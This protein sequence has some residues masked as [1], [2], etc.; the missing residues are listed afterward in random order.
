MRHAPENT[1]TGFAACMN[2]RLGFE[3]DIRRSKDGVLVVMHDGD[4]KRTTNGKGRVGD[5]TLAEIKKLDAGRWFAADF[6][7]EPVPTLDAVFALLKKMG[8]ADTLVCLDI[9]EE[10][11]AMESDIVMLAKKH[12]VLPKV[13]CIGRAILESRARA[14]LRAADAKTPVAVLAQKSEDLRQALAEKDADWIYVRFMPTPAEVKAVHAQGKRVFL[15]GTLSIGNEPENWQRARDAGVDA[16]LTD[17]P[18]ECQL[19][20]RAGQKK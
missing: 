8:G 2:L 5:L 19:L 15:S 7:G 6:A 3:L 14:K 20:W 12:D 1:L 16:L 13:L 17:Y 9:K 10:D 18:L 11:E 4:V